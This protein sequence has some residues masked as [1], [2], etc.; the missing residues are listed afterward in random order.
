MNHIKKYLVSIPF[1]RESISEHAKIE[2][3]PIK[4]LQVSIPFKRES[5]SEQPLF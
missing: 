1:K 3:T 4:I 2:T 5:I